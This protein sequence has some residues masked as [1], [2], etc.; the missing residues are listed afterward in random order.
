MEGIL[1][2][3][4]TQTG[5]TWCAGFSP[6]F[7][8]SAKTRTYWGIPRAMKMIKGLVHLAC[9]E[10]LRAGTVESEEAKTQEGSQYCVEVL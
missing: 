10:R 5:H 8:R 2:A 4:S 1:P 6:G 7:P 3:Y 9:E